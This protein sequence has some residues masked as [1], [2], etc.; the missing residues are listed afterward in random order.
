VR[1]S[2]MGE[3]GAKNEKATPDD[4]EAMAE[5]IKDG[6]E[7]GAPGFSTSRTMLHRANDGKLVPGTTASEDELLGIGR[8]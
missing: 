2:V 6:L 5:I 3:R 1:A 7:A 8:E 4:I